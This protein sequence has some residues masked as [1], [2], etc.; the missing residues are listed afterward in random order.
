MMVRR[1]DA[2]AMLCGLVGRF[3]GHLEHVRD[4]IGPARGGARRSPTL[5]ALML[6]EH[7][8]FIADTFVNEDPTAEELAEIAAMA[9]EA[10][11]RLRPAAQGRVPVALDVRLE[12][13]ALRAQDARGAR[14]V[15]GRAP[16]V[17][18]DGEMHGDAALSRGDPAARSCRSRRSRAPRTC[19]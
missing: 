14:A 15:R 19:W 12:R 13:P 2:D 4:V 1:G 17:E 10:V 16:E 3:D 5:N 6:P 18:C 11:R 7:T 8:I 9:A